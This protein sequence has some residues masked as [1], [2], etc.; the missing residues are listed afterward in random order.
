VAMFSAHFDESGTPDDSHVVLTVAGFVSSVDKWSKFELEW[1]KI[2]RGAGLPDGTIF[3][4]KDFARNDPPYQ[5]FKGD[6]KRKAAFVSDLIKCTKRNVNKAFSFTVALR[7]WEY[8]N[9]R[10]LVAESL[11]F[12]YA[13]CG[14]M[15]VGA[16]LKWAAK[17]PGAKV[18][19]YFEDGATHRSQLKKILKLNDNIE[20]GFRSKEQMVQFQPADLLAWK[21][22]KILA[23]VVNYSGDGDIDL[24][25]SI[26]R[27]SVELRSIPHTFGVH[28]RESMEP[29]IKRAAIPRRIMVK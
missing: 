1:P 8:L 6:S 2:L 9:Q 10:F 14:R 5:D 15:C 4:M 11:G 22:R 24:Y 18:E 21:H 16:V 17:K 13:F 26:Q 20:P 12:P 28:T 25:N 23:S 29:L 19:F 27:S 7:D 3:H